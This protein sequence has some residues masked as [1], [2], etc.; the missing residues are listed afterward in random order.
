MLANIIMQPVQ[1]IGYVGYNSSDATADYRA[2][3]STNWMYMGII[4]WTLPRSSDNTTNAFAVNAHGAVSNGTVY[5]AYTVRP[6]FSLSSNVT[7][8][9]G[10]GTSSDPYRIEI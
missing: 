5:N 1:H 8:A 9:S 4:E 7:Y 10:S 3:A 2:A 6:T